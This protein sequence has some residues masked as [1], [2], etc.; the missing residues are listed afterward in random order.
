MQKHLLRITLFIL[1]ATLAGFPTPAQAQVDD[2]VHSLVQ[3]DGLSS[4]LAGKTRSWTFSFSPEIAYNGLILAGSARSDFEISFVRFQLSDSWSDWQPL[5]YLETSTAELF[6]AGFRSE[7]YHD[8]ASFE[9]RFDTSEDT[10]ISILQIGVFDNRLDDDRNAITQTTNPV[11][12]PSSSSIIPPTLIPRGAWGADSFDGSPVPL[13]Q[14]NYTRMTF[15][16]AACCGAFTYEEGIAQVKGI[17]NFHQ[18]V[19][20]WSD[21]GYHFIF[22][23][24]G[25]LYQGRP[26]LDNRQNLDRP[27]ILAQG[28]HV[29]GSNSGNIGVSVLGCYHPPEGGGCTDVLSP[30]LR[31]SVV[32]MLSYLSERYRVATGNLLGHRDQSATSCPGDNNYPLLPELRVEIDELIE[33]GNQPIAFATLSAQK[34]ENEVIQLSW[35]FSQIIDVASY[36]IDRETESSSVTLFESTDTG[37]NSFVDAGL[38]TEEPV[39]YSLYATSSTG[40]IQRLSSSAAQ[41]E[42]QNQFLLGE[43]FPDP[44]VNETNIRYFLDHE[45]I[46]SLKVYDS[47][48]RLIETLV[49]GFQDGDRWYNAIFNASNHAN[50]TYYYRLQIEGFSNQVFDK[51]GTMVIVK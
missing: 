17:Q 22:D 46:V 44:F 27:P 20:G 43:N 40:V 33:T 25:R 21:I 47:S 35:T 9:L 14:P 34:A 2:L 50:G 32:T 29:G 5:T 28:A 26:F 37:L 31:D 19:R 38:S 36:Q 42:L 45:G 30:A 48:G 4:S 6:L 16:H 51:T 1:L 24:S 18:D 7:Q 13:A 8:A 41:I 11:S 39:Q 15:H 3:I 12:P 49:D 10:E 23:Q